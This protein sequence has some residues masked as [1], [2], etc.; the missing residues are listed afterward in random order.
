MSAY[1]ILLPIPIV[2][3]HELKIKTF[4][5]FGLARSVVFS[6]IPFSF[7]G[8]NR[9]NCQGNAHALVNIPQHER[10]N[11]I[12]RR[13]RSQSKAEGSRAAIL[14]ASCPLALSAP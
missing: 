6:Y 7:R 9:G 12:C 2:P 13:A 5:I 14:S 3:L 11:D 4:C 8:K 10:R 1:L